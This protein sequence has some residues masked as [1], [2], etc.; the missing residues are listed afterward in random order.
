[1]YFGEGS[2]WYAWSDDLIHWTPSSNDEPIMTPTP[3]TFGEFLVEVGPQP[4]LTNNGLI[5][6]LH[7]A[8]VKRPDGSVYY[9][10]GQLLFSPDDP[11]RILAQMNQPWLEPETY[12]DTHGL[13]SN[14][15]FVEG[16]VFLRDTWFAYYGQSD[17]TLGVAT[18]KLGDTYSSLRTA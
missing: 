2:I 7:N 5:L 16:L 17:S 11:T 3:G 14:V 9:S 18:Y 6:L 1:M 10:C 15:T 13:V 8:A 4:I 12:E